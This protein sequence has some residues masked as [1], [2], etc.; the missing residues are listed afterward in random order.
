MRNLSI[1]ICSVFVVFI[2][3]TSFIDDNSVQKDFECVTIGSQTWM[4]TNLNLDTFRNGDSIPYAETDEAWKR[5]GEN[6]EPAWCYYN[7]D[8]VYGEKYGKL[9]NWHAVNDPRG[10]APDGWSIPSGKEW[11]LLINY[12]GGEEVAG[13]KMKYVDYWNDFEGLTGNGNNESGFCGLPS[14]GRGANGEFGHLGEVGFWWSSSKKSTG[15]AWG[16]FLFNFEN[17]IDMDECD[18]EIGG[19]IRCIRKPV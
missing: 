15:E 6:G 4:T 7:N 3:L 11:I 2:P 8:S 18:I 14:G 12:L 10:L 13:E 9:Y 19:A 1:L 16:Y 17:D 5:A